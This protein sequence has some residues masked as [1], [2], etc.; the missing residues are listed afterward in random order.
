MKRAAFGFA[1]AL[2]LPGAAQAQ[3]IRFDPGQLAQCVG[4]SQD[5]T[6]CIGTEAEICMA[7]TEGGYSTYGMNACTDAELIWWDDRLNAAYQTLMPVERARDGQA[8]DANRP[9]GATTLRDMQR[10]WIAYRDLSCTYTALGWFGGTGAN[11]IYLGCLMDLTARQ[12][13]TL[14]MALREM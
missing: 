6:D 4:Q 9:S 1:V 13:L 5:A 3:D 7:L 11:T 8:N 10:A 12:A 14:E 2:V